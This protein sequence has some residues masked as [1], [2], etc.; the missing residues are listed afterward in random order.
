MIFFNISKCLILGLLIKYNIYNDKLLKILL[1]NI[2]KSGPICIK[3]VQWG[4]PYMK[5]TNVNNNIINIL[6]NTYEKCTIHSM[7]YTKKIFKNDFYNSFDDDYEIINI[8]GSGSI[9]Q[10]YKIKDKKNKKYYAMKVIH[11]KATDNFNIIKYYL[12]LLF[13]FISFNKIIP[14]SL[15]DFLNQFEDQLNFI[16]ETNNLLIFNDLYKNN[17]LYKIPKLYKFS[18]NIIIM[19]YIHGKSL[20]EYKNKSIQYYKYHIMIYIFMNNNLFINNFNHSDLH[21]YNWKITDDDKIVIYDFGLCWELT[22]FDIIDSIEHL[23]K[24]FH[25]MDNNLIY[26]AFHGFVR[27]SST[28]EEKIIKKYF[29]KINIKCYNEFTFHII[30]FFKENNINLNIKILYKIISY[31]NVRLTFQKKFK[32]NNFDYA[33]IYKEEL[34]IC[35]YYNIFPAYQEHLNIQLKKYKNNNNIDYKKLYKFIK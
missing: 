21:N 25:Y 10:V 27:Y 34:T 8:I 32:G 30:Y 5:L 2:N 33:G 6:E 11:P 29:D 26:K 20:E 22:N 24:G 3:M 17:N 12:K 7:D 28:I 13:K 15:D 1:K 23:G 19:E 9:A 4:L 14:V 31:Q 35:D 16:N 18:E